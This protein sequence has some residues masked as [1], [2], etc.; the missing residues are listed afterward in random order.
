MNNIPI[1]SFKKLVFIA[2]LLCWPTAVIWAE[3]SN[4]SHHFG[5][6]VHGEAEL[7]VAYEDHH[8]E[9]QIISPAANILGFEHRP[10]TD[11]QWQMV[12]NAKAVLEAPAQIF[13]FDGTKCTVS[14]TQVDMP[15]TDNHDHDQKQHNEQAH[16]DHHQDENEVDLKEHGPADHADHA[17]H[18]NHTEVVATYGFHCQDQT[19]KAINLGLFEPFPNIESIDAQWTTQTS[20]SSKELDSTQSSI[21]LK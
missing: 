1:L 15:F 11:Q 6:H 8:L 19:L 10:S 7:F 12:E 18:E 17:D 4:Q 20:Q 16:T 9:I 21:H 5:A 2:S 13:T 14:S 3:F